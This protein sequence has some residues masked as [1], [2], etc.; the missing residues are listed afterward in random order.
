MARV[1]ITVQ[2][3]LRVKQ[4]T[5]QRLCSI[6]GCNKPRG[7]RRG[8]C[9]MHYAR[10]ER[11]GDPYRAWAV[12]MSNKKKARRVHIRLSKSDEAAI[13]RKAQDGTRH[14]DLAREY[15]VSQR[16]SR[17]VNVA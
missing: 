2:G 1:L 17:I 9:R 5:I 14:C 6:D 12:C 3:T 10:W 16:I 8:W 13:K 4:M 7:K 11:H 15:G